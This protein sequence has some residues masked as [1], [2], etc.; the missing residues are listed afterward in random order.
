MKTSKNPQSSRGLKKFKK[1]PH[2]QENSVVA[3]S[4][5]ARKGIGDYRDTA[6]MG[7]LTKVFRKL[8][9]WADTPYSLGA[10][11]RFKNS[12]VSG[13]LDL[14][15]VPSRYDNSYAFV[16]DYTVYNFFRK[17]EATGRDTERAGKAFRKFID[18]ELQCR[19]FNHEFRQRTAPDYDLEGCILTAKDL[20]GRVLPD[21]SLAR[22]PL[23]CQMG[24]G[25]TYS[26][27]GARAN[28]VD[29]LREERIS[30]TPE[31]YNA[32]KNL[33]KSD[34]ALFAARSG[35]SPEGPFSLLDGN[36]EVTGGC[37]LI[38]VPKTFKVDRC[39]CVEPS[40][41]IMLQKGAGAVIR[42]A[43]RKY[44][45]NLNDQGKN[46]S[47]AARAQ[48]DGLATI[49]LESASDTVCHGIVLELLPISWFV[50]LDSIRSKSFEFCGKWYELEKFSAMGNGFTFE[51]E[52][53]I[54]WALAR[55]VVPPLEHENIA[56][57]GD[58]IIVPQEY[59]PK[60]LKLLQYCGFTPNA[61][62]SFL[63]G[64]FFESCGK[65]YFD[66][67]DVTPIYQK[68]IPYDEAAIYRLAN[69]LYRLSLRCYGEG[70]DSGVCPLGLRA[71]WFASW[72]VVE[73][74]YESPP[75]AECDSGLLKQTWKRQLS[76]VATKGGLCYFTRGLVPVPWRV[77][78]GD[79]YAFAYTLRFNPSEPVTGLMGVRS[80]P[81]YRYG[82][83]RFWVRF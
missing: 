79:A 13:L 76:H 34:F 77:P 22:D 27:T 62:K 41:N 57:Y 80:R 18:A 10:W 54:F 72:D 40:A 71:A 32:A 47:F 23:R 66:G 44:G 28:W 61:E 36:F 81:R 75:W 51:L 53:L 6:G 73:N 82:M 17:I 2:G 38:T 50:Y 46:Q 14:D 35:L 59:A 12:G 16:R 11:L 3:T 56:V 24:P 8:C 64:R 49:D 19:N 55:S 26:L 37:R 30:V 29:K 60:L 68:E 65:H 39:I 83:R 4:S 52:S 42:Q 9:M 63:S 25:A 43:L 7:T 20:I 70:A 67:F 21:V 69:R 58:D 78:V 15:I 45:V 33:F 74:A 1:L 48:R 31:A 5:K